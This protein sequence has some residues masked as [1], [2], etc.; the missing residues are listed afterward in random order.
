MYMNY[1]FPDKA[2]WHKQVLDP[3]HEILRHH[4][5]SHTFNCADLSSTLKAAPQQI[6]QLTGTI[7]AKGLGKSLLLRTDDPKAADFKIE[8]T[9]LF[10]GHEYHITQVYEV[11]SNAFL[12]AMEYEIYCS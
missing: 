11:R 7:R 9:I 6:D 4:V 2:L 10:K 1:R 5:N 12:G 8:D 3:D